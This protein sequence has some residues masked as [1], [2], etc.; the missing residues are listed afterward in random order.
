[1]MNNSRTS[2]LDAVNT[3]LF[4]IGESPV[5]TLEG[6]TAVDAVTAVQTLDMVTR[7]VLTEGWPFN[8]EKRFPLVRHAFAPHVIYVPDSALQCDLPDKPLQN[9]VRG[10]PLY[11]LPRHTFEFPDTPKIECDIVW[12]LDF[13]ELP[14]T[15]RRYIAVRATRIFQDGAVG[16]ETIHSF[17]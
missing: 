8:T 2:K 9:V 10:T 6:G 5:N 1:M 15:A 13:E 3:M 14:E 7:E 17:T 16:S 12:Y 4:A 11:D